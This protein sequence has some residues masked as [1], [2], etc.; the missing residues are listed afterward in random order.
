MGGKR[1][2][3]LDDKTL[4]ARLREA[5]QGR[6]PDREMDDLEVRHLMRVV[7][8]CSL[9]LTDVY[10]EERIAR[11]M[12]PERGFLSSLVERLIADRRR[13]EGESLYRVRRLPDDVRV[14][15]DKALFDLGVLGL[16]EIKGYS[17]AEL[18]SRAYRTA[19][20]AL[21]LLVEDRRLREFFKQNR[22]LVLPLE[23]EVVFLNQC[24]EKFRVYAEILRH[25]H[26]SSL[27]L[28]P[29]IAELAARIP[30]M[31]AA[32]EALHDGAET[33]VD[34]PE[35]E[36]E[37]DYI[38][39][40]QG[41]TTGEI[42][43]TKERLISGYERILLFS[44]LEMNRLERALDATVIDQDLAVKALCDEFSLFAAGTRDQRKPPAY[45]LVG[46]TGVGKNHLV[47]SLCR[48]L[49]GIWRIE[50]PVL[51]LEGP[52]YTYPSDINELRGATR[53]FIRSDED[54][55]LTAFHEKSQKAPLGVILID[56][57][58]KAHP[59]LLTFFLSIL[60]RGTVTDNR[61]D[62]LNFANC[63]L[64][65]TSNLGY[66]DAQQGTSAIGFYDDESRDRIADQDVRRE[67]RGRL[68]PEF[69][70]RVKMIHFSRL[71]E[72]SA[73]RILDLELE[74]IARRYREV[75]GLSLVLDPSARN[76]L[77]RRGFSPAF[78][79]RHLASTL[80]A[81]CNVEIA[82]KIRHDDHGSE[83]DRQ[84]TIAWLREMREG[85]RAFEPA[86]V[87]RRVLDLARARLDYDVLRIV[88]RDDAF[89]FVPERAE[90]SA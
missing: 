38:E 47:E 54:G 64:F 1:I 8:E 10:S 14:V 50:I 73:E 80:E 45:F 57:I 79:A 55:I 60:D 46:P 2:Q 9:L 40:A 75:H 68:K 7:T 30:L 22:L 84:A 16:R 51:T 86:A 26:P 81:V 20:E 13:G 87:R 17:L 3:S 31:A 5:A 78:G 27:D 49:E 25:T 11:I 70:N 56:E 88:F 18:G 65:F 41:Q 83:E 21:E 6:Y 74:R 71:T 72:L 77:I 48:L 82:K 85:R 19:A 23:E 35:I 28:G 58:E 29:N 36:E 52:N 69:V 4:S 32:A 12:H 76:E 89:D 67:L 61:G 59:H 53:G 37:T 66:S 63:M 44:S 90:P 15:G 39:A 24:S 34:S 33:D 43:V 62:L 42:E